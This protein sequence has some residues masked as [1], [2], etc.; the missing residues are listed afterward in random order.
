[1]LRSIMMMCA[2][3]VSKIFY[4]AFDSDKITFVIGHSEP[5]HHTFIAVGLTGN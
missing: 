5:S 4:E 1:M 3:C 2:G